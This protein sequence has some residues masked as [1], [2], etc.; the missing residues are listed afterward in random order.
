MDHRPLLQCC[1][2][3]PVQAVLQVQL[4][5]PFDDVGEQVSIERRVLGQ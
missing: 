2:K 1:T 3:R 5:L 4:A